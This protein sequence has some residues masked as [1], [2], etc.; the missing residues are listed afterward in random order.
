MISIKHDYK[1]S[2]FCMLWESRDELLSLYNAVNGTHYTNTDDLVINTLR[3]AIYMGMKNDVSFIFHMSLNLYEHQSTVNPNMPLRD[4]FYVAQVLQGMI[5]DEN[6]YGTT[7]VMIPT[8]NFVVFYNGTAKQPERQTLRLSDSFNRKDGAVNLELVVE[9]IN[10]NSGNNEELLKNCKQLREY[11]LYNEKVR[12]YAS[13]MSIEEAVMRAVDEC[14]AEGILADFLLQNKAEAIA[15]S[16]FEYDHEAHMKC[17]RQEGYEY[18]LAEGKAIGISQ[19][20]SE[21]ILELLDELGTIPDTLKDKI[22]HESNVQQLKVWYK[23]AAKSESIEFFIN[24]IE[25]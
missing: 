17:V 25:S 13:N 10:I 1:S 7:L 12:A 5:K 9:V 14:I 24:N 20:I 6:L 4:L 3:N 16:I 23:L 2:M 22:L 15:M 11:V 18:G 19:G 8:P 21:G